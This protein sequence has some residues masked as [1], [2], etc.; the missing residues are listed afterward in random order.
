MAFQWLP[1]NGS[2]G[3]NA[4]ENHNEVRPLT[5]KP[6]DWEPGGAEINRFF[7]ASPEVSTPHQDE[8]VELAKG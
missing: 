8:V 6:K 2:P 3:A 7:G 4:P 5:E 1:P